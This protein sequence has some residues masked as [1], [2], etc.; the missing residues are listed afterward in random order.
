MGQTDI[1]YLN[2]GFP[3]PEEQVL[4]QYVGYHMR[5]FDVEAVDLFLN[6]EHLELLVHGSATGRSCPGAFTHILS[7]ATKEVKVCKE[8]ILDHVA[9]IDTFAGW[10]KLSCCCVVAIEGCSYGLR[11]SL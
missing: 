7:S 4:I 1:G 2:F 11:T 9:P 8:G 10:G 5:D 6:T 3:L